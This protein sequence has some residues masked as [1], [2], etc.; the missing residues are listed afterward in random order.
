M[1]RGFRPLQQMFGVNGIKGDQR[2]LFELHRLAL[3]RAS[4]MRGEGAWSGNCCTRCLS[5]IGAPS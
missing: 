5:P 2:K 4:S 3:V 1:V